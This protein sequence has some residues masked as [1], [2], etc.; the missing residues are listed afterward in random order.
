MVLHSLNPQSVV[1]RGPLV[2]YIVPVFRSNDD[3]D[4]YRF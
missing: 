4:E 1:V 2:D 3:E